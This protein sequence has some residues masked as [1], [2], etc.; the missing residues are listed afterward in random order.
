MHV[1]RCSGRSH[2]LRSCRRQLDCSSP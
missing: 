2:P 1:L